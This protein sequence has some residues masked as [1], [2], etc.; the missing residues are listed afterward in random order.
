MQAPKIPKVFFRNLK[1]EPRR[2]GFQ[3]R[4]YNA[5]K[6]NWEKR[7][8]EIEAEVQSEKE[9]RSRSPKWSESG[10]RDFYKKGVLSSNMR[11]LIILALL[12][13]VVWSMIKKLEQIAN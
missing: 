1:S 4:Y 5:K 9:G 3:P 13:F 6:E 11:L 12:C 8:K 10:N 7:K 2:F